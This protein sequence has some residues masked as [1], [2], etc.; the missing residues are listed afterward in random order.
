MADKDIE[1]LKQAIRDYLQW[2]KSME[3]KRNTT[4]MHYTLVL[5]DFLVFIK[6][7]NI[8]WDN[9]FTPDTLKDFRKCTT[10]NNSSDAIRALSLYLFDNGRISQPLRRPYYQIDLPDIYEQYLIY[11]EQSRQVPY[12]QIKG[13]RRVL[14]SFHEYLERVNIELGAIKIEQID[15]FMA[16]FHRRLA[17]GTCKTYRFH[18]RG[19]LKYLYQE[20]RILKRDLA[21]LVV[22]APLFAQAKPPKFLRPQELQKL[23]ADL[24]LTTPTHIRT[25]AMV[26]LAYYMGLRPKEISRIKLNDISFKKKELT[27]GERKG[28]NPTILPVPEKTIKAI[29]A[30]L[31]NARPNSKYRHLFLSFQSPYRPISP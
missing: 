19:F 20:R 4:R 12:S 23:F 29:A 28:N 3:Y 13:I 21:P 26:H 10:I 2:M 16:Q 17:P 25:Y 22:G 15:A 27:I 8:A 24:K 11:H 31:L 7:K 30:Y 18:L 9:I 6:R 5:S 1:M 14:A